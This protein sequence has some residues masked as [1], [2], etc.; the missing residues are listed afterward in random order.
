MAWSVKKMGDTR[1]QREE[2]VKRIMAPL[3]ELCRQIEADEVDSIKGQPVIVWNGDVMNA[4]DALIGAA[5]A[6]GRIDQRMDVVPIVKVAVRLDKSV[7]IDPDML[8]SFKTALRACEGLYRAL[9]L[10]QIKSA[11]LTESIAIE[12][13]AKRLSA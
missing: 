13:E 10:S 8:Q 9:P 6:F 7:P 4:A 5:G 12:V 1:R 11:I 2:T 3:W